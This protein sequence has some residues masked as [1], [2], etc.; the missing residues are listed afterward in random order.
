MTTERDMKHVIIKHDDKVLYQGT[1]HIGMSL[2]IQKHA[3]QI[4]RVEVY[5][6]HGTFLYRVY[7]EVPDE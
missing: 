2:R 5:T 6:K 7:A 1:W 3:N 4:G